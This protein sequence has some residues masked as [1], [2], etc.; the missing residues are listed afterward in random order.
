MA[1]ENG[2][3]C[4]FHSV[5]DGQIKEAVEKN[6]IA[7]KSQ[8]KSN[9]FGKHYSSLENGSRGLI[10]CPML[11]SIYLFDSTVSICFLSFSPQFA[12]VSSFNVPRCGSLIRKNAARDDHHSFNVDHLLRFCIP[13]FLLCTRSLSGLKSIIKRPFFWIVKTRRKENALRKEE[14]LTAGKT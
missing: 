11:Y 6:K 10:R 9:I 14:A 5:C 7:S 8:K 4:W 3:F 2:R 1:N 13:R 12:R